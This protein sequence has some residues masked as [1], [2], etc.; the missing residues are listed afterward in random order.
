MAKTNEQLTLEF[1][2]LKTLVDG[3]SAQLY[4][5]KQNVNA[6]PMRSDLS[7]SETIL[8]AKIADNAALINE[9]EQKLSKISLPTDT[10]Y[11]LEESEVGSFRS[12]FNKLLAMMAS[13][14]QLYKSLVAYS[15]NNVTSGT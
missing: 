15:V 14:E 6:R 11:Y 2:Q 4:E 13:F 12:N 9:I 7:R 1:Q 8:S 10:R 5:L 3:I